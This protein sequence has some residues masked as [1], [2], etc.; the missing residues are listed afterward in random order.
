MFSV[1]SLN[2]DFQIGLLVCL[3]GQV[4][5][6]LSSL[7]CRITDELFICLLVTFLL[8]L[9]LLNLKFEVFLQRINH[10]NNSCSLTALLLVCTHC[11]WWWGWCLALRLGSYLQE[12]CLVVVIILLIQSRD[13][14]ACNATWCCCGGKGT[15][16]IQRDAVFLTEL[17]LRWCLVQLWVVELV[18]TV[19]GE[20]Q[21]LNSCLV[22]SEFD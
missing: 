15:T 22:G 7:I 10:G 3:L 17:T 4:L 16:H 2:V 19:L 6:T 21:K 20:F 13:A 18:H 11:C 9:H 8:C 12:A 14:C 5:R 1:V